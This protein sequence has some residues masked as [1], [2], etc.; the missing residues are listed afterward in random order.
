MIPTV[1]II[2]LVLISIILL[3]LILLRLSQISASTSA[4]ALESLR[5]KIIN[6]EGRFNLLPDLIQSRIGDFLQQRFTTFSD[7][8]SQKNRDLIEKFGM[9]QNDLTRSLGES[10]KRL[11]DDFSLFKDAFRKTITEDFDRLVTAVDTKLDLINTKVQEN[12]NEGFKKTNETF[13]SVIERLAKIDEAQ[14]TIENLSTDV[15]SLQEILSD[16]KSRGIFGEVQLNQILYAVFGEK[17]DK[18]FKTQYKLSTGVIADAM[19]FAPEPTGNVAVDSKFPLENFK[20]MVDRTLSP[21]EHGLATKA[22]KNDVRT[23]VD[24]IASKYIIPGETSNQAVLFLPAEAIFAEIHAYHYDLVEY[25]HSRQVWLTSPTTFMA[26]LNTLQI[27]IRD[28]ERRKFA[29]IIQQELLKLSEDFR[30]YRER[31]NKLATHIDTVHKDVKE[32]HTTTSKITTS[33]NRIAQVEL[34]ETQLLPKGE[35]IQE[36]E[37]D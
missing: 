1:I 5:E 36:V 37:T 16:K 6:L 33:F 34:D 22:F 21:S 14:K 26:V 29:D 28:I 35:D 12:L 4:T 27:V 20:R 15:V 8:V 13:N 2:A 7:N 23:K 19:L 11:S 30:R 18:V 9:F 3:V 10:S 32:I 24:E 17:N 25:A 31:W